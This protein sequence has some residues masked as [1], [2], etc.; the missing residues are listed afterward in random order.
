MALLSYVSNTCNSDDTPVT[1][2]PICPIAGCFANI[3]VAAGRRW[4]AVCD[5]QCHA[6]SNG[7]N[8]QSVG[9]RRHGD[10]EQSTVPRVT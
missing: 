6:E 9:V 5:D 10:A 1:N 4:T 7:S 8:A 3:S 2:D